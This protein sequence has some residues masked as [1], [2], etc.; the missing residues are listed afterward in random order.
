MEMKTKA[1][2]TVTAEKLDE[3]AG[4]FEKG[5]WPEGKTVILGR[6]RLAT[7]E[8][9]SVTVKLPRSKVIALE[10]KAARMGVN[11]S[12]ALREAVD[13]FLALA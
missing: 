11:R 12:E 2:K 6:P 13:E 10:E 8:V 5:V 1:G 7:E 4:E 3:W 9:Q